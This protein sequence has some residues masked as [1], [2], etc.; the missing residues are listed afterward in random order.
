MLLGMDHV[1]LP[2]TDAARTRAFYE[3]ALQPLGWTCSGM[4]P[5]VYVGFKKPGSPALYFHVT[6]HVHAAHLAFKAASREQVAAFHRAALDAGGRDNGAPG[7]RAYHP[8]YYAAFVIDP[9]GN[10]V[11]AVF[12][13]PAQ[14]SA[15]SVK[16]TFSA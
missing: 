10:N 4:R 12:H 1:S 15:Q 9:D 6:E 7:T 14:K 13:G 11:E 3:A 2:I 8:G 5:G 16:I